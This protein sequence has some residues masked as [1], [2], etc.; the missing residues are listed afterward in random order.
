MTRD[1][2]LRVL[3]LGGALMLSTAADAPRLA[4]LDVVQPGRWTLSSRDR[5]FN[6]RAICVSD[7][8]ALFQ[9]RQPGAGCSRFTIASDATSATV[10]YT[11]PGTGYGRT[12][13]RVETPRLAQIETQGFVRGSPFDDQIEARRTGA[14][15][16]G[17]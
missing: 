2:I 1:A 6:G 10:H 12:T 8:S 5:S 7:A 16:S 3:T 4:V 17:Q 11:C 9:L 14:C 15:G 13:I